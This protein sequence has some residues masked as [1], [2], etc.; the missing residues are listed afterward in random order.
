MV[1]WLCSTAIISQEARLGNAFQQFPWRFKAARLNR[2]G[3][4]QSTARRA[5]NHAL[6][7][8]KNVAVRGVA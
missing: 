2:D 6:G 1:F 3:G 5:F 4:Q 7:V 8:L